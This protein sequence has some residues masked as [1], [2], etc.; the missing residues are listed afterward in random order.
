VKIILREDVRDLGN[1]GEL[2]EVKEGY[3]RNYLLPRK[4]AVPA[5][6]GN[7]KDYEKRIAQARE[8]DE[9][10]RT[11]ANRLADQ[12]R[13]RRIL[14][15]RRA[16]DGSERLHGSVTNVEIAEAVEKILGRSVDRRDV[17]VK[18][19]IR[20]LG[21]H[22][23]SIKLMK[24]MTLPLQVLVA[25]SEPVEPTPAAA[26]ETPGTEEAGEAVAEAAG[27]ESA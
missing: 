5:T 21:E 19:P 27:A 18:R 2:V 14:I 26:D 8:R 6:A 16:A 10:E 13:G 1:A 9:Q 24:G 12:L 25:E 20:T 22:Q 15:I 23:A 7:V 11:V 17:D 4:M 3:A